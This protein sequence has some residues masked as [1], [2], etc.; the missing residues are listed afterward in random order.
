MLGQRTGLDRAWHPLTI[1]LEKWWA[2]P[3][4][5]QVLQVR[6]RPQEPVHLQEPTSPSKLTKEAWVISAEMP[7]WGVFRRLCPAAIRTI[8]PVLC[9]LHMV[10][11]EVLP[12][13]ATPL[14][15]PGLTPP[16]PLSLTLLITING[17]RLPLSL[18][19]AFIL[20]TWT[21]D[22]LPFGLLSCRMVNKF[23]T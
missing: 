16:Q 5:I 11:V 7:T 4:A 19:K 8:L 17:L 15:L 18:V 14:T 22:R 1:L 23:G 13:T 20:W 21:A 2:R 6:F 12:K 3:F 10:A 9:I